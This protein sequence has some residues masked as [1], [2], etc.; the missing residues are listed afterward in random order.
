MYTY[1]YFGF[2][3]LEVFFLRFP[4]YGAACRWRQAGEIWA[5][6]QGNLQADQRAHSLFIE[7]TSQICSKTFHFSHT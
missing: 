3:Y 4:A 1:K 7:T 5:D 2:K 6:S